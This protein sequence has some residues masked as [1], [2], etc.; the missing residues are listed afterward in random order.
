MTLQFTASRRQSAESIR[1][2]REERQSL[3]RELKRDNAEV[4]QR[5]RANERLDW[6]G[7]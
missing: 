7:W 1:K 3:H 2:L 4:R 5:L 6:P